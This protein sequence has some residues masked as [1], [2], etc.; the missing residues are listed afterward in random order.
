M[1]PEQIVTVGHLDA[2]LEQLLLK[3]LQAGGLLNAGTAGAPPRLLSIED[4]MRE[5]DVSRATVQRWMK[6]GKTGRHGGTITLQHYLFSP[7]KPRIPWPALAAY[8]Q[9]LAFDL[10]TLSDSQIP[11]L[12]MAG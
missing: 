2:S 9:G 3:L 4:V 6:T 12:R 11:P 7:D 10:D 8:G 5:C 1:T